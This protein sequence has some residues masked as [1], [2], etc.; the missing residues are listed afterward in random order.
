MTLSSEQLEQESERTRARLA[1][2]LEELRARLT[3]GQVVD[4]L[5]DYAREGA[6]GEFVRNFGHEVRRNPLPVTLIGAGIGW[7]MM[8]SGRSQGGQLGE[9]GKNR[10]TT[11]ADEASNA[12]ETVSEEAGAVGSAALDAGSQAREWLSDAAERAASV[13]PSAE[14]AAHSLGGTAARLS[15]NAR[16]VSRNLAQFCAEEPLVVAGLGLALGAAIGAALPSS[17]S[18]NQL[19]GKTSDALKE[20]AQDQASAL[21]RKA[22]NITQATVDAAS[23]AAG[24]LTDPATWKQATGGGEGESPASSASS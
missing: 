15:R 5:I 19:L 7:L 8:T 6:A 18:E 20:S 1:E 3:P 17:E 24:E 22:Q 2:T 13:V 11:L 14:D 9:T 4:Q 12:A 10:L 21:Y 23:E 16:S